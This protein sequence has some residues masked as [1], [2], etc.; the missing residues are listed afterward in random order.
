MKRCYL[1][2]FVLLLTIGGFAQS[3]PLIMDEQS[4]RRQ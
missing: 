4:Y 1:V 3:K 2:L